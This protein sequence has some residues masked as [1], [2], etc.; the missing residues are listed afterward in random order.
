MKNIVF[1]NIVHVDS[2][3]NSH[4]FFYDALQH[5]TSTSNYWTFT[6]AK[7]ALNTLVS[8]KIIPDIIFLGLGFRKMSGQEFLARIKKF[9]HLRNI[10]V[11]IFSGST[12]RSTRQV[13]RI[14][15]ARGFVA[16]PCSRHEFIKILSCILSLDFLMNPN[17]SFASFT[18]FTQVHNLDSLILQD[19]CCN[20]VIEYGFNIN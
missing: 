6:E 11:I 13:T 14:L 20:E 18:N 5:V 8:K 4:E 19:A 17:L 1:N 10:P 15:G 3:A 9:E 12:N 7:D 2:D 16:N